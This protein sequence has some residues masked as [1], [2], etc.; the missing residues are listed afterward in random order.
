V[1]PVS[2][3]RAVRP[4]AWA[5]LGEAGV[6]YLPVK[7]LLEQATLARDGIL[8]WFPAF[9][10]LYVAGTAMAT[11][12]RQLPITPT[13]GAVGGIL[14]GLLQGLLWGVRGPAEVG[15]A[16]AVSSVVAFRLVSLGLRVWRNPIHASFGWGAGILL[17]EVVLGG[18]IGTTWR[19]ILPV[20]VPLFFVASLA[21][22]AASVRLT[23]PPEAILAGAEGE[24][25]GAGRTVGDRLSTLAIGGLAVAVALIAIL[26]AGGGLE[27][28]GNLIY[29]VL[30]FLV[31]A[32]AFVMGQVARPLLWILER[33]RFD[34]GG[35]AEFLR[36]LRTGE[37]N[38]LPPEAGSNGGGLVPR[39]LGL[40]V[41]AALVGALVVVTRRRRAVDDWGSAE[42]DPNAPPARPVR[43][44]AR[45][46]RPTA[47]RRELPAATIRRWYAEA[48]V[49]L[50]RKGVRRPPNSTP[51]E[52]LHVVSAAFPS[53]RHAFHELTRGYERVRYGNLELSRE[54][55]A[56]LEPR[57]A[58][59]M[60]TL[61][62]SRPVAAATDGEGTT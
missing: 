45:R 49:L 42:E 25:T 34:V 60:E 44:P 32:A 27:L 51:E 16:V 11:R 18:S 17:A 10:L 26:T 31:S 12:Y 35:L 57:W 53:C 48:L 58:H 13:V 24:A 28:L 1:G 21:S 30:V 29:P 40:L 36:R 19:G 8:V 14:V 4:A 41:L 3:R 39:L 2:D 6:I 5:A 9:V 46:L 47:R 20:I 7:L 62:R 54:E 43:P 56:A 52:F 37:A 55:V 33:L 38:P 61:Q 15:T 23:A 59:V 50:E 22:R